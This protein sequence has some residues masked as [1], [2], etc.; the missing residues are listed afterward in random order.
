M[1]TAGSPRRWQAHAIALVMALLAALCQQAFVQQSISSPSAIW[2]LLPLAMLFCV[3]YGTLPSFTFLFSGLALSWLATPAGPELLA[4][5]VLGLALVLLVSRQLRRLRQ[6][7]LRAETAEHR[8]RQI[9]DKAGLG[10][11]ELDLQQRSVVTSP[12]FAEILQLPWSPTPQGLDSWLGLLPAA[13]MGRLGAL[14]E[15]LASGPQRF[16][17]HE[18]GLTDADGLPYWILLCGQVSIDVETRHARIQGA[19]IDISARKRAE[20]D[21]QDAKAALDE[22]LHDLRRLHELSSQLLAPGTLEEQLQQVLATALEIHRSGSGLIS[23]LDEG[24]PRTAAQ[25]G[26]CDI[27]AAELD[28][29]VGAGGICSM[30]MKDRTRVMVQD[31]QHDPRCQ[32]IQDLMAGRQLQAAH[33]LPLVNDRG[34]LMGA[35]SVFLQES[36]LP[37]AR[38]RAAM[39]MCAN[40]AVLFMERSRSR[41]ALQASELRFEAVLDASAVPFGVLSPVRGTGG[42][43][44][45]FRLDYLNTAATRVL[46]GSRDQLLG[47]PVQAILPDVWQRR[48]D[49]FAHCKHALLRQETCQFDF[50]IPAPPGSRDAELSFHCIASPI[51]PSLA[52]WAANVSDRMR[53]ERQLRDADRR[54]DEFIATLAHELRNL[55]APIRQ[56]AHLSSATEATEDQKRWGNELIDRQ[57]R[58]MALLLD[59]LLDISRI[60]RGALL[61]RLDR[62]ELSSIVNNA[63]E[64]VRPLVDAKRHHLVVE[65]PRQPL[66]FDADA[67]RLSQ[68]VANLLG[69]AAKY[70]E[71][72]GEIRLRA[73]AGKGELCIE[74]SDNGM[75]MPPESLGDVFHMYTRLSSGDEGKPGG[76][77]GIGLA[78]A[79]GLV[80]LHGGSI[81]ADSAGPGLGSCFT[82]RIPLLHVSQPAPREPAAAPTSP[83]PTLPVHV[84]IADDNQE[85]AQSLSALL[86]MHGHRVSCAYDGEQAVA[87]FRA[88]P[89][90]VCLLDIGMPLQDGKEVAR[91]IRALPAGERPVLIAITGWGQEADRREAIA[92]GFDHHL[93]KPVD[94]AHVLR[95][96]SS[97]PLQQGAETS[98]S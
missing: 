45:D 23:V 87:A 7:L 33:A 39:D 41:A 79:R 6:S 84:L 46:Q 58:H 26:F 16:F 10:L 43:L 57:V 62:A 5:A 82:V 90:D 93:T 4:V 14:L 18:I 40:K 47:Q 20:V 65:L 15:S 53:H 64:A 75:G 11:F 34:E 61:L 81:S 91:A 80:A 95:L 50:A 24:Q 76:G 32:S 52:V 1:P 60:S 28:R 55:L 77:L 42:Q 30:A 88:D 35:M 98:M 3:Q 21:L 68:V 96:I 59:D 92:A 89:A 9:V 63:V 97:V 71:P 78:L 37:S 49:L 22:Q 54:K 27:P 83:L 72:G 12:R 2:A 70:T 73:Q 8:Q 13:S 19:G 31:M 38:E 67:L 69:N 44:A 25:I 85:A 36:R 17:Q 48:P 29:L 86:Q 74:V 66:R 56:A 51:G 94:P